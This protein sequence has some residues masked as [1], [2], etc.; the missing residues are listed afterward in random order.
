MKDNYQNIN[1]QEPLNSDLENN[2]EN[3]HKREVKKRLED[4]LE[5]K[6][7]RKSIGMDDTHNYWDEL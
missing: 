3:E 7:L 1:N 2:Q 6:R 5:R 4:I